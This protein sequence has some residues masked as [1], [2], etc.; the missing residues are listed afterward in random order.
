MLTYSMVTQSGWMNKGE[1]VVLALEEWINIHFV[2]LALSFRPFV[3]I[4]EFARSREVWRE[5][6]RSCRSLPVSSANRTVE[7]GG[8]RLGRSLMKAEKRV[9]PSMDILGYLW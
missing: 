5:S 9:G 6:D 4:Q 3:I 1:G 8:R 2:L 7:P